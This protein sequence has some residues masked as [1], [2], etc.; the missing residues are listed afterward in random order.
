MCVCEVGKKWKN[1][2]N[3]KFSEIECQTKLKVNFCE[4]SKVRESEA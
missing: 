1:A 2:F 4:I 3:A